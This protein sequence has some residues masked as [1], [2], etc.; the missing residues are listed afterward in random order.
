[1][2][3]SLPRTGRELSSKPDSIFRTGLLLLGGLHVLRSTTVLTNGNIALCFVL[4]SE[5][6]NR[7][8]TVYWVTNLYLEEVMEPSASCDLRSFV[9]VL[10]V[11]CLEWC[12]E[13]YCV[14]V[15]GRFDLFGRSWENCVSR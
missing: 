2:R 3:E 11:R 7:W 12:P 10:A 1:M 14:Y 5:M 4:S 15:L 8:R 6:E 13:K 9:L